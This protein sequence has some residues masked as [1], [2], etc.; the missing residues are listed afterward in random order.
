MSYARFLT[1]LCLA[2]GIVKRRWL[3]GKANA[4]KSISDK[5]DSPIP[6]LFF[7]TLSNIGRQYIPAWPKMLTFVMP[8]RKDG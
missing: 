6:P 2:G 8:F 1:T 5:T 7:T 3:P 4:F